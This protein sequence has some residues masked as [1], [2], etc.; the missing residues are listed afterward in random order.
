MGASF[1]RLVSLGGGKVVEEAEPPYSNPK[2]ATNCIYE[3][4]PHVDVDFEVISRNLS[5]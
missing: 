3:K 5:L 1:C 2:G 4:V